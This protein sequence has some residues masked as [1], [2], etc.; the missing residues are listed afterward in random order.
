[1][2]CN[3]K[4]VEEVFLTAI[5]EEDLEKIKACITLGVNVNVRD[6]YGLPAL[7]RACHN[8]YIFELFLAQPNIDVNIKYEE[9]ND[10]HETVLM[11]AISVNNA[12]VVRRL[13][14]VPG[15]DLNFQ[16]LLGHSAASLAILDENKEILDI[17]IAVPGINWNIKNN[18]GW[19]PL[20]IA[21]QFCNVE[22]LRILI[23]IPT[24]DF[25]VLNPDGKN[26][27]QMVV[28][29]EEY[30]TGSLPCLELLSRDSRVNWNIRDSNGDTPIMHVFK[31]KK[32]EMFKILM[33]VYSIDKTSF[34]QQVFN[35]TSPTA[36]ECPICFERFTRNCQVFQC[37]SGHFVC[38]RC[39]QQIQSCPKCR[40][41][42]TG[43]A[44]DFEQFMS[45]LNM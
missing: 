1:M 36:P 33:N 8:Y 35:L 37:V 2:Y 4:T 31:K 10:T 24:L 16:N 45:T 20:T 23:R 26:I 34:M 22:V 30:D 21:V 29:K 19:S 32:S 17:L 42:M 25:S 6:K 13:C 28:E 44:H 9:Y 38:G 5:R 39:H 41:P 14:Q 15:I 27:G 11:S 40:G 18:S 43:R 12:N 7:F 3:K